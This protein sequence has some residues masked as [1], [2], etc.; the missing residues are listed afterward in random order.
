MAPESNDLRARL[1]IM[2]FSRRPLPSGNHILAAGVRRLEFSRCR[3]EA[4]KIGVSLKRSFGGGAIRYCIPLYQRPYVWRHVE[5]DP[6]NDRLGP[7]WEGVKQ[8]VDRL[9]EHE[10]LLKAGSR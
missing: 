5:G 4:E 10:P 7:F 2:L 9:V 1:V 6:E 8:T 3:V